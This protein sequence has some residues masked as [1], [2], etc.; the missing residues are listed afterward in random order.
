MVVSNF[1][2]GNMELETAN[3]RCAP[4]LCG[5]EAV[6]NVWT[7]A[8]LLKNSSFS[9]DMAGLASDVLFISIGECP[10]NNLSPKRLMS[11]F[12]GGRSVKEI[13]EQ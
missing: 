8:V 12:A 7:Q 2:E 6:D 11:A 5:P 13:V 4:A 3:P 9:D 1:A 10:L